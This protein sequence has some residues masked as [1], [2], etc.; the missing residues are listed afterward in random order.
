MVVLPLPCMQGQDKLYSYLIH[1][2]ICMEID[3][4]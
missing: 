4:L 3:A 1:L 2:W